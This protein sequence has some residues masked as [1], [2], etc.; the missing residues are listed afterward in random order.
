M[1]T[2][3]AS[4]LLPQRFHELSALIGTED[5]LALM[6]QWGG[7]IVDIPRNAS[8]ANRLKALI[9]PSSVQALCGLYG[10]DRF[11]VPTMQSIDRLERNKAILELSH[12]MSASKLAKHF[13]LSLRCVQKVI[14]KSR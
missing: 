4:G 14:Q 7:V 6:R 3:N 11:Y 9:A 5:T 13:Q 10:G 12:T 8:R 1:S 2:V